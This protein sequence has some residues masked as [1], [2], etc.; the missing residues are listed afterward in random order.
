ML[1]VTI[2]LGGAI[3]SFRTNTD[4]VWKLYVNQLTPARSWD[5]QTV[6]QKVPERAL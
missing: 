6:S 5:R 2:V 4:Q 1:Q 3:Q